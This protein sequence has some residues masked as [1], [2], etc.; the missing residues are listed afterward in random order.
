MRQINEGD[1]VNIFWNSSCDLDFQPRFGTIQHMPAATGDM[2]YIRTRDGRVFAI[3]T[4]SSSFEG[5]S[6]VA[7]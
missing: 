4:N 2:L 3:N 6:L 5:L 7:E 1:N